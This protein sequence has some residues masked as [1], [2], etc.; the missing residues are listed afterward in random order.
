[1]NEQKLFLSLKRD[2]A[3]RDNLIFQHIEAR[4]RLTLE[5]ANVIE[6]Y[7]MVRDALLAETSQS[8]E[9]LEQD[10]ELVRQLRRSRDEGLG[11]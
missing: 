5:Q 3:E 11:R 8:K 10:A 2:Q 6:S 7:S 4:E 9:A 1:M